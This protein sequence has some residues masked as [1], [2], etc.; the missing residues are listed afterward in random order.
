MTPRQA[1]SLL[2]LQQKVLGTSLSHTQAVDQV[3]L[4][5]PFM[6]QENSGIVGLLLPDLK[7]GLLRKKFAIYCDIGASVSHHGA[8]GDLCLRQPLVFS[9][10]QGF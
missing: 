8:S 4:I 1:V 10:L 3:N 2:S 9:E 5:T 6:T 7:A